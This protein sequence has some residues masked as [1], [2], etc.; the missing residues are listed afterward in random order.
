MTEKEAAELRDAP[1]QTRLLAHENEILR[2][3]LPST[4]IFPWSST[5]TRDG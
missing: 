3:K 1:N 2:R 4:W 5:K